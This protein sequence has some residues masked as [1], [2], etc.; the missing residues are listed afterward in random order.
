M[1]IA[2]LLAGQGPTIAA[3]ASLVALLRSAQIPGLGQQVP[4]RTSCLVVMVAL[5]LRDGHL[6]L[7]ETTG[8]KG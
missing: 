6:G 8:Q 4:A 3:F 1:L 2:K 7:R 5:V